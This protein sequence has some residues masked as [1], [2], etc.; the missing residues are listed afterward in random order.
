M[1]TTR[2]AIRQ[3]LQSLLAAAGTKAAGRVYSGRADRLQDV[4]LPAINIWTRSETGDFKGIEYQ[5]EV[6]AFVELHIHT[7]ATGAAWDD[8]VDD[9]AEEVNAALLKNPTLISPA[10]AP[11]TLHGDGAAARGEYQRTDIEV[12]EQGERLEGAAR[13]TWS[14]WYHVNAE[15]E[16]PA[17]LS[18]PSEIRV[19]VDQIPQDGVLDI[20]DNF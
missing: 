20:E 18:P 11:D 14:Y 16:I 5:M 17:A 6:T 1:S 7:T 2:K 4:Q 3:A 12:D 9:F 10:P 13:I 8:E 19:E 15:E